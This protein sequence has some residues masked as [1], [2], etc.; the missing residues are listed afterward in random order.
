[1][2][3]FAEQV[4]PRLRAEFPEGAPVFRPPATVG[5]MAEFTEEYVDTPVGKI[6]LF[7]RA[8]SGPPLVYLHS[9]GGEHDAPGA[10]A[11]RRVAT[12]SSSPIFPGFGESEGIEQIDGMEDAVFHLLDLWELLGLDAPAVVGLSLGGLDG[13]RARDPVPGAVGRSSCS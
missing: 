10:R 2:Q 4:L 8:A 3:L 12:R 9:A 13:A 6:Q 11:A 7:R 1:M 5:L